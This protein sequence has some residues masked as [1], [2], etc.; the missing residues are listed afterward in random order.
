MN[1]NNK[2]LYGYQTTKVNRIKSITT[3]KIWKFHKEY[4]K[5]HFS[6][7][8]HSILTDISFVVLEKQV[9]KPY[10]IT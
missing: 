1:K 2:K 4:L 9:L 8:K 5:K 6:K 10:K 7:V 3:K